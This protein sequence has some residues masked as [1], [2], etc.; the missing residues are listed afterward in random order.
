MA[1][2]RWCTGETG[3]S[4]PLGGDGPL[5]LGRESDNHF[6]LTDPGVSRHHARLV[7]SGDGWAIEDLGSSNGTRVNGRR[8]SRALLRDG[9]RVRLCGVELEFRAV[10]AAGPF[11]GAADRDASYDLARGG[12]RLGPYTWEDLTGFAANGQVAPDDELWG[13]GLDRWTPA[14]AIPGLLPP[15]PAPLPRP[16][17]PRPATPARRRSSLA[18]GLL[19]AAPA[20]ALLLLLGALASWVWGSRPGADRG[21]AGDGNR[22]AIETATAQAPPA[23]PPPVDDWKEY[24]DLEAERQRIGESLR[25]FQSALRTGAVD[26]AVSWIAAERQATYAALFRNKPAAMASFADLLEKSQLTFLAPPAEPSVATTVRTAEYTVTIDG[27][28]F[29][30]RWCR[31]DDRWVLFDF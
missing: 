28:D 26:E 25:A 11:P 16:A 31:M 21:D 22:R 2:I 14:I 30:L 19:V 29:Y 17:P 20:A 4:E 13:P 18:R 15:V 10:P 27:F 3:R 8:V 5:G 12:Q 9:D 24:P 6:V 1:E 23:P 7:R